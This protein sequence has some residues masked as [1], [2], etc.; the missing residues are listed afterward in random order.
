MFV[1]SD[2][3]QDTLGIVEEL[4][5]SY[6]QWQNMECRQ[7]KAD[8]MDLD[9]DGDG[10]I[11]LGK[12]YGRV[13]NTKYQFTESMQYLQEVGALDE[14]T[15]GD[16]AFFL[17]GEST[18]LNVGGLNPSNISSS[19]YP[20][21]APAAFKRRREHTKEIILYRCVLLTFLS[22]KIESK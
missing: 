6:G 17:D 14:E 9:A 12:F 8:L 11:P 16:M 18:A 5:Y 3:L 4:A 15:V 2:N 7:M 13:D 10:R 1:Y 19:T 20:F 22:K 21:R